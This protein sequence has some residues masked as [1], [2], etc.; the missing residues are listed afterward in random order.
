L[1]AESDAL[2]LGAGARSAETV[3]KAKDNGAYLDPEDASDLEIIG[4][5]KELGIPVAK[6]TPRLTAL[7]ILAARDTTPVDFSDPDQYAMAKFLDDAGVN[8]D[9][10]ETR[11][12]LRAAFEEAKRGEK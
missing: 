4:R 1:L 7:A 11:Y 10:F 8:S 3:A 6:K 12:A 2:A 5:A 9:Q